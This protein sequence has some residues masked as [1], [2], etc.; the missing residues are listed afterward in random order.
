MSKTTERYKLSPK[1]RV[2]PK[3]ERRKFPPEAFEDQRTKVKISM[4]VDLDV[5]EHFKARATI[6]RPYQTQINEELRKIME[7][8]QSKDGDAAASLRQ[9]KGLIEAA[10]RKIG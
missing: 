1:A 4:Y 6:G 2:I 5:L 7:G 9:A 8:E 10:L 3:S